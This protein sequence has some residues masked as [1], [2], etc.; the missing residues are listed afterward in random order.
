[1]SIAR[2]LRPP[3]LAR[4]H[5]S[6]DPATAVAARALPAPLP[7][8]A[9]YLVVL[10]MAVLYAAFFSW[11]SIGRYD[12][13]L[14]HALD[15]GNMDQAVWHTLHGHP[16]SFT[17]MRAAL[18]K[19]AWGTTSRLSFHVEPILL[20]LSLLYLIHAAPQTLIVAQAGLVALGA[21]AAARLAL[22]LTDGSATLAVAAA[23]AYLLSPQLQA[24]TL[25]EFHPVTL[26]APLLLWAIVFAEERRYLPFALCAVAAICCKEEIGLVVALLCL[27]LWRRGGDRRLALWLGVASAGWS[28]LA[29]ELIV[30]H[31]AHG[32]S[33]YW[34]RYIDAGLDGARTS[35]GATGLLR[36]WL[37]HPEK[38]ILTLLWAPKLAY[39][40]R[41]LAS[42]GYLG[43]FGLPLLLVGLP[44][45][46]VILLSTDQHMY[47]GVGHY[48][49]ELVPFGVAAALYGV[50]W[51]RDLAAHRGLPVRSIAAGCGLWLLLLALAN[52]RA[53]GFTPLASDYAAP[54][55]SAHAQLGQRLLRLIP[56]DAVVSAQ[57]QLDPHL[58]DRPLTYLF[59][60]VG[61]P[62]T[63]YPAAEYVALDVTSNAN[64]GSFD[65]AGQ[66]HVPRDQ[67]R[68]AMALLTSRRYRILA[69]DDGYL[70]LRRTAHPLSTV[71][72]LPAR[73][74]TFML[75]GPSTARPLVRF[76]ESLE[77]LGVRT[78]RREQ[79]NLRTPDVILVATFRVLRPLPR[80][81][82]LHV[83]LT[84]TQGWQ[85][86]DFTD[87]ADLDWLPPDRWPVG[88]IVR[89][90]SQ[91][92]SIVEIV[93]GS[94]DLQLHC[95][96]GVGR[97]DPA[98]QPRL[99]GHESVPNLVVFGDELRVARLAVAL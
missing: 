69:A 2:A 44:S 99:M 36:Y 64:P 24:A 34:Q 35:S 79:V 90:T 61:Q 11:Y 6:P 25:Y 53:N 55:L 87:H 94:V 84:D 5:A 7:R 15:M 9:V 77:L 43:I 39:L 21:P 83:V 89:F 70:I 67:Q 59:P 19:E 32:A 22:R 80:D 58:G 92:I 20:P 88:A 30:P 78:L 56:P 57:D 38:P 3:A 31:F 62:G 49:A 63:G 27:W 75:S 97:Q 16:F 10:A 74:F 82:R 23:A 1:L 13:F 42:A 98:F 93:P 65:D 52:G 50:A 48:S 33:A 66:T 54:T 47:G 68:E 72:V 86:N 76:G 95:S 85:K 41:L 29:L 73:F 17:N 60:D 4:R 26:V 51:L 8:A 28:V 14:M 45:L 12:A 81:L 96:L 40:N 46:A 91:Q 18:P 71:P 37:Q